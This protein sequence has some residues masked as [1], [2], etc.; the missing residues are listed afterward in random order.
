M[1]MKPN[2][3]PITRRRLCALAMLLLP[4]ATPAMA[5]DDATAWAA[6]REGAIVLFRHANAP[7]VGDPPQFK[8]GECSTQR[9]LDETG[10]AQSRR[11]GER[12]KREAVPV[13]AVWASQWCRTRETAE[14]AALGPVREMPAFNS[15]FGERG[16]EPALTATARALLLGWR[17]GGTLVVV[18]HQ[19][20]ISA[21]TGEGT[22][23]GEGI[24]LRVRGGTLE[25]VGRIQP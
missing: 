18:T 5:A 21:L 7:G 10:R 23:S 14:L 22:A 11:I 19:V 3:T 2:A 12:L 20:N 24:V 16:D 8:L 13:R 25:R 17:E 1:R 15:F 4:A 6:L 9:N